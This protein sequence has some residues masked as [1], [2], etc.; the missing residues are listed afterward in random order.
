MRRAQNGRIGCGTKIEIDCAL[1]TSF[2]RE[3]ILRPTALRLINNMIPRFLPAVVTSLLLLGSVR[4]YSAPPAGLTGTCSSTITQS[5]SQQITLGNS[6]L[7]TDGPPGFFHFDTSYWRAFNMAT[8]AGSQAYAVTSVSFGIDTANSGSGQGQPVHVRLYANNGGAFPGG[9]RTPLAA[10]SFTVPDQT[11]TI[12]A[13]PLSAMV[14]AGTSELVMEVF[15]PSGQGNGNSF[16]IGSNA[17]AQTGPSYVS[18]SNCGNPDPTDT[19]DIGFP[20]MHIVFNVNGSCPPPGPAKALNISTRLRAGPGDN[21]MIGGFIIQGSEFKTVVLRGI[22][23]SLVNSGISGALIDPVLSLYTGNGSLFWFDDNWRDSQQ[24][25]IQATGLQPSDD[26]E[27]AMIHTLQAGPYTAVLAE[28]NQIPGVG[29]VEIYDVDP[30]TDSQLANIS[31]RGFVDTG[32]NVMI[33]GFILGGTQDAR[34]AIRGIGPSLAG[35]GLNNVL[36]DPTLEL[37]N[38]NG[39][40]LISNDNWHDDP[41]SAAQLSANGLALQNDLESGIFTT[42]S[43]GTYTAILAGKNGGTGIGLVEVYNLQ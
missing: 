37:H 21:A 26:R 24:N 28:K 12:Q 33:G 1:P 2:C 39:T 10:T 41:S 19:A 29:L 5:S 4:I 40:T 13:V 17:A 27:A 22:G 32:D 20:N 30:A 25:Q 38:G 8:F 16:I 18:S 31:T 3:C 35:S 11:Q 14:P 23:P 15:T 9:N 7:C 43:P 34:L 36:A 6:V 42:L